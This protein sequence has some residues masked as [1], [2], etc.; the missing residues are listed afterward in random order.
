MPRL[1]Y[2][3]IPLVL[4]Y[5]VQTPTFPWSGAQHEFLSQSAPLAGELRILRTYL[6]QVLLSLASWHAPLCECPGS[7]AV[8]RVSP[9]ISKLEAQQ[10]HSHFDEAD[11][12]VLKESV[13]TTV[14][15]LLLVRAIVCPNICLIYS[16][17]RLV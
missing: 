4:V 17:C 7:L 3:Y 15:E 2:R 6:L 1:S 12:A 5:F 14:S 11:R 8:R 10:A 9:Q 16:R 13:K